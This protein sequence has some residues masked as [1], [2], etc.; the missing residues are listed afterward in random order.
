[1]SQRRSPSGS[2]AVVAANRVETQNSRT[3]RRLTTTITGVINR[4]TISEIAK[5]LRQEL[6][7]IPEEM[8][9]TIWI[10]NALGVT[11]FD[12][13][14]LR[15]AG[16]ELLQFVSDRFGPNIILVR[17]EDGGSQSEA[18]LIMMLRSITFGAGMKLVVTKDLQGISAAIQSFPVKGDTQ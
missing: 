16:S 15:K 9:P 12:S 1:M 7:T 8:R 13:S 17:N 4:E 11:G 18:P 2:V 10:I 14:V 3:D 5:Q 6:A